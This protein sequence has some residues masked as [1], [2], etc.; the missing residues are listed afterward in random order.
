MVK[1]K[2]RKIN[3]LLVANRGEIAIRIFRACTELG[4]DTVA[5]YSKED[6][7]ALHRY[8]ADESYLVG[9][10]KGP[11]EAYLDIEG[12][13]ELAKNVGADA[14]HPGYG[15]LSENIEFAKRCEEEG[16]IFV[17]PTSKHL[18]MFGDKVKA[19]T[20]AIEAGLPIIPGTDGPVSSLSEVRQFA[21]EAGYPIIIKASL[22]GGGRGMRIV[23][24]EGELTDAY[25]RAR[26][27]AQKAFG[28]DEI[29]V[30][31]F[32]EN[33]KHIEV[34]IIGDE[35]GNI[36]HLYER[37][38]S[39]QRRH[40]KVIEVA[41]SLGISDD[42]RKRIT[43]AAVKLMK[44]V[45]YVNAGTVEFLVTG[46]DFYFIEVNPRIQVEHTITEMI[47]G[48]DIVQTQIRVAEG[49]PLHGEVIGI[50]KQE[51][52]KTRGYAIQSR[53]T[54][55]DPLNDFMPDTGRIMVYRSSGGFGIRL[56]EGNC[57][58]GAVISPYYDSLLVKVSTWAMTFEQAAQ[59]MA[60]NLDEFRIRGIKTNIPFLKN[61][62]LHEKFIKGDYSTKFIDETPELFKF[63]KRRDRGT[64]LLTYIADMTVNGV[65]G[66]PKKKKPT[67]E[68]IYVP[69][70]DMKA[71]FPRGT[72]QLLDE[73]GPE[74]VAKWVKE[75]KKVLLT[76][77]TFR[78]AHQ[79]LLATRVRTKDL[80][81][82]AEPTARLLPNLFSVEMWGGATFDV[83]YRFL[84]EDPWERLITLR[85]KMPN[86]LFQMLLRASNAVGYKNYPDNVIEMFV[87]E[88]A[89]AGIDVFRIFD[90][91][92][93]LEG[94][95]PAIE[96]VRENNK[97]VEASICYT[98]NI[99]DRGREKYDLS[100]YIN[101]AKELEK[102]GAHIL[103][104][105]DMAGL[106]KPEAAYQLITSL[107][108][109]VDIPIHLHT[110]DTSGNGIYMYARAIDAGVD[111]VDVAVGAMA[112]STSQPSAQSL[113][114]ALEGTDKQPDIDVDNYDELSR[115]WESVRPYYQD[116]ESGMNS[117]HPQVYFHEMP[118]GQYS[119]L[120][121]QAK[122][123][124]LGD[125]W[126]EVVR[127][128][129]TVND[130][131]GDIV[132]V[133][134]SS[135]VVG[136]M[137]L[138]MVQNDLTVE[139][140]Y[141]KGQFIDFPQ[142]VI[143]FFRGEIGQPYGGFPEKLQEIILKGREK[144]EGRPGALLEPVDFEELKKELYKKLGR[145]ITSFDVISYALYPD[146]Y[147]TYQNFTKDYY[148]VSVLD[149]PTY[150]Y[151][152]RLGEKIE[153][154]IERGKTLFI[155]LVSISEPR[156]DGTRV[157]YFEMN[158]QLREI[159]IRDKNI[160]SDV[161]SLP[162]ADPENS[163]HI[164]ATMPGTVTKILC[165]EGDKVERGDHLLITEAMK[166]ETTIQAPFKGVIKKIHVSEGTAIETND[167]L[168]EFE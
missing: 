167:L 168:L 57:Y 109:V 40:Q 144:I 44:N 3:K 87:S 113:Y 96:A 65:D 123:V 151:G 74:Y 28:N 127:M 147:M 35:Y 135:K 126:D 100:Y 137:A 64:K 60:R 63:P 43:D 101:L 69:Q 36:V 75:Q 41:P 32:I 82:I 104:I 58:Q 12:I 27:E 8:K 88:S 124:G 99:L 13:I 1:L 114:H 112:G 7:G 162:K 93:W 143:E 53:I 61:V 156:S 152:M 71:P 160:K 155:E 20:Q 139:D 55:E 78:D 86:I 131:F 136:D 84:R 142:S 72:K 81:Q 33:P 68:P 92:N 24:H 120:Q 30:E 52:I 111:I 98:G 47:T 159:I 9:E 158:G 16:I 154:E 25:D 153:V 39:I 102:S 80:V 37:D 94:M 67:F 91:L 89:K 38:C 85:Q 50:P 5:I 105:K 149:T 2:K 134:P 23:H 132:K 26:S 49:E 166:M 103:G 22:G 15:F 121:Q 129:R 70:V 163:K 45:G 148:D 4:I 119:N 130:M 145:E 146:V 11:I 116:F 106:L 83:A 31:K 77:T 48:I 51:E 97:I 17:G 161:V 62:I 115:Y 18:E 6:S 157:V 107:K 34:Q 140:I 42:L 21:E 141:E 108:E 95:I 19:K 73:H 138:F 66:V 56:D 125:R 128:Y 165:K 118:G 164:G 46:D 110:H 117:P 14:I 79:S 29:Y 122:A 133:T 54:T 59:K 90:S 76:D 150:F 10:G